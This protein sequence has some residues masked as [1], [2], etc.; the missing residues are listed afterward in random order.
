MAQYIGKTIS[1]ISNKG[2]RYVG[3][4]DNINGDEGTVSLTK[5][6]SLGT[7]G[8]IGDY[9]KEIHPRP[10]IYEFVLFKGSDVKDL[11]ILDIPADQVQAIPI[12]APAGVS[13]T[14]AGSAAAAA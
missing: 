9:S 5:V 12:V 1:L 14:P 11:N 4:L 7:E 6:R 8:R 13:G 2:I 3:I 10:D